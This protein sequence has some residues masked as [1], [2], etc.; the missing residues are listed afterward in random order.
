MFVW[1]VTTGLTTRRLA[2]HMGKVYCVEFNEDAS[3]LASGEIPSFNKLL[4]DSDPNIV[5][6]RII[7]LVCQA[8]GPSVSLS[9]SELSFPF[10]QPKSNS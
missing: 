6:C 7:R 5:L 4:P 1:D 3:V 10:I 9:Y 2:G 8:V